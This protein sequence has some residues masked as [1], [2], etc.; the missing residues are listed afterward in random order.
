LRVSAAV[1]ARVVP[2]KTWMPPIVF[3]EPWN[4]PPPGSTATPGRT[5]KA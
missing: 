4:S 2:T 1:P 3:I 5:S